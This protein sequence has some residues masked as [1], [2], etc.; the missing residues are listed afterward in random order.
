MEASKGGLLGEEGGVNLMLDAGELR[1]LC[2]CK[3]SLSCWDHS[4]Q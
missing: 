1:L 2:G 3:G 4:R